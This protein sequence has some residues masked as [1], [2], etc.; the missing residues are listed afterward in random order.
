LWRAKLRVSVRFVL[1]IAH[2]F[3]A[4]EEPEWDV[5]EEGLSFP[6]NFVVWRGIPRASK[7]ASQPRELNQVGGN[8]SSPE[9]LRISSSRKRNALAGALGEP[10]EKFSKAPVESDVSEF[11]AGE[12]PID[13][14]LG[15][16]S[17]GV[18]NPT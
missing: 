12:F 18:I 11:A 5:S 7:I 1:S 6:D 8:G 13:A 14:S 10:L 16:G 9:L 4:H 15:W 3:G 2:K 17:S